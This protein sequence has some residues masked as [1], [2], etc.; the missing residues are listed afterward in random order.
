MTRI[1]IF[2][3]FAVAFLTVRAEDN[4]G[5]RADIYRA[6]YELN[7]IYSYNGDSHEP[8]MS[9]EN[10][11]VTYRK[12]ILRL[13]LYPES[14]FC[15]SEHTWITDSLKMEPDG[16]KIWDEMFSAWYK[17]KSPE[18]TYPHRRS[19]YK[20][21]KNR[22]DGAMTIYDVFDN[23]DYSYAD[24]I[25]DFDWNITDSADVRNGY[26]CILA[27]CSYHG[28]DWE[29]W[30]SPDLPWQDGPWKFS[31]LPGLVVEASD[32]QGF[33]KFALRYIC[34]VTDP[35]KP[36]AKHIRETTRQKFL[37]DYFEYLEHLD[38]NVSAQFDIKIDRSKKYGKRYR[39]GI[40][41]DY[42]YK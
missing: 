32:S 9:D 22:V 15:Y 13:E 16:T 11:G 38:G 1:I 5:N 27:T 42:D 28:R 33:Y 12:D 4:G 34:R 36:W 23:Q 18:R 3:L 2:I 17:S 40:E 30:F 26:D 29:V 25:S 24:N 35:I 20:I 31:G 37:K 14:S 7:E 6:V 21:V 10:A 39:V 8:D 19:T 41:K